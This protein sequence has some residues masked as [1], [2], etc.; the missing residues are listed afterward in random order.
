[1][2]KVNLTNFASY[3]RLHLTSLD[4]NHLARWKMADSDGGGGVGVGVGGSFPG[5]LLCRL[6]DVET[7]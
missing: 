7:L 2:G 4:I 1:M 6:V 3:G 5:W